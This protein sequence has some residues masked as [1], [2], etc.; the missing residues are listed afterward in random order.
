MQGGEDP[1]FPAQSWRH[2][3]SQ[4]HS[5][6]QFCLILPVGQR[7]CFHLC[8]GQGGHTKLE[9]N[10]LCRNASSRAKKSVRKVNWSEYLIW[11]VNG[12]DVV[13]QENVM[14]I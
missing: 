11:K 5:C 6:G 13:Y 3:S 9:V 4:G 12:K 10:F 7:P 14:G 8:A 1:G 2:G